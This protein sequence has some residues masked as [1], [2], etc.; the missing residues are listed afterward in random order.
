MRVSVYV[1]GCV[2][3][4]VCVDGSAACVAVWGCVYVWVCMCVRVS[5]C[6][7]AW[8]VRMAEHN[9]LSVCLPPPEMYIVCPMYGHANN[10]NAFA[11]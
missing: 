3:V 2:C 11:L 4:C 9:R 7:R 10:I 1:F 5:A 6:V 8:S